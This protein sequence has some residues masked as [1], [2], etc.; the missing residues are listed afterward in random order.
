[1]SEEGFRGAKLRV[2]H[3]GRRGPQ[4]HVGIDG[5][6]AINVLVGHALACV[7]MHCH[8][9]INVIATASSRQHK[10]VTHRWPGAKKVVSDGVNH[11]VACRE[12]L[13]YLFE[14]EAASHESDPCR[15]SHGCEALLKKTW[16]QG[17][18]VG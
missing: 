2:R 17:T 7:V 16:G 14:Y 9:H 3:L 6:Q 10:T 12:H 15:R 8:I 11:V 18:D 13:V 4:G 1:M 5:V